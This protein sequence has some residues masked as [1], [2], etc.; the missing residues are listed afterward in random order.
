MALYSIEK[1]IA[2]TRRI[3][4]EYR[5]ATGK[6]L[7]VTQELAINDAILLL[8]LKPVNKSGL[9]YDAILEHNGKDLKL[10][11]KGRV[12]FDRKRSGYR[13]GQLKTEQDWDGIL[14][15]IMNSEF[16]T[17]E[18]YLAK[19]EVLEKFLSDK[20]QSSK[21]SITVARFR[22][23]GDLLWDRDSGRVPD[24]GYWSNQAD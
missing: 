1:L 7:P 20:K 4:R 22:I 18:I 3:A 6:T 12:I 13:L 11:I 16:D 10:Q 9:G 19:R 23:I 5:Q 2:E 15:V 24:S 8:D 21:G 14:L 17:D